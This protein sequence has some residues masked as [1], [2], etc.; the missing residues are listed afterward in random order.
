M[1]KN[2]EFSNAMNRL[3]SVIHENFGSEHPALSLI[4]DCFSDDENDVFTDDSVEFAYRPNDRGLF[5]L[6]RT[7]MNWDC[8]WVLDD[9]SIDVANANEPEIAE[10]MKPFVSPELAL[11]VRASF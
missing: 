11:N 2:I 1:K 10:L 8:F 3:F 9:G 7:L 5:S 4:V 6:L